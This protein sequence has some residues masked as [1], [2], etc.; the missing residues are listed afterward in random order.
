VNLLVTGGNGFIGDNFVLDWFDAPDIQVE[1]VVALDALT[2]GGKPE[3]LAA[4]QDDARHAL[5]RGDIR[6]R[7]LADQLL[8]THDT[9]R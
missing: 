9:A 6:N 5:V 2:F 8:A 3:N 4:L 7:A 1:E